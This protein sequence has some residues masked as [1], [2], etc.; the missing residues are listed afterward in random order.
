MQSLRALRSRS[1]A[2]AG[3]AT[4]ARAASAQALHLEGSLPARKLLSPAPPEVIRGHLPQRLMIALE[5]QPRHP[6]H[7]RGA[8]L[9]PPAVRG[10]PAGD[11][12][13]PGAALH[14]PLEPSLPPGIP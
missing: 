8:L 9:L 14:P 7:R 5:H 10:E 2:L 4:T 1:A 12:S 11:E 13:G 6:R 3:P